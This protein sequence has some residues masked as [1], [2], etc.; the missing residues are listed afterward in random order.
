GQVLTIPPL[1][2]AQVSAMTPTPMGM[3][4]AP[5][6]NAAQFPTA[7]PAQG[8][9]IIHTVAV[10]ENLF[11]IALQYNVTTDALAQYNGITD[12]RLIYVGQQLRIP[13]A[14]APAPQPQPEETVF[15][16]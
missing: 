4:A 1:P 6:A 5:G 13:V 11:R 14:Q 8:S 9:E 3:P 7:L 10:G 12:T 2:N 15:P 16:T